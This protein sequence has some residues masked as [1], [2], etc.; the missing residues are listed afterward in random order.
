[1]DVRC[2][3]VREGISARLDGEPSAYDDSAVDAHVETCADCA[4]FGGR[5]AILHRRMRLSPAPAVGDLTERVLAAVG[6]DVA[7]RQSRWRQWQGTRI[8]LALVGAA[9]LLVSLPVLLFGH[10]EQAPT[11]LAHEIGSFSLAI[12][13]GLALAAYRPRLA[14]GM[15]PIVGIIAGLLLLTAG[16]DLA[17]GRTTLTDEFPHL[18]DMAGFL[19]LWRLAKVT[20]GAT[21]D[22]SGW[23]SPPGVQPDPPLGHGFAAGL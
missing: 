11:H 21:G 6:D 12:A 9:Q 2:D 5:A 23:A 3:Q 4:A 18:L 20:G 15:L 7:V 17:L 14:A 19:L 1:M 10:D 16:T 13:I 22:E 8:A